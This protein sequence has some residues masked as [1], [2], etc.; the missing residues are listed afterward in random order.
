[1]FLHTLPLFFPNVFPVY[2]H[3]QNPV[4]P[5]MLN[6]NGAFSKKLLLIPSAT[7]H[8]LSWKDLRSLFF[9]PLQVVLL[10]QYQLQTVL[11]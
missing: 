4:P 11:V 2:L 10:S 5:Q 3:C 8:F 7:S 1:M 6:S 9:L